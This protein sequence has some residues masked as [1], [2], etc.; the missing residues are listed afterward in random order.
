[1]SFDG[2]K[3]ST[4]D[5]DLKST[6]NDSGYGDDTV[7]NEFAL[8]AKKM[9][10]NK[11]ESMNEFALT[12]LRPAPPKMSVRPSQIR[13]H[14]FPKYKSM[15]PP[16]D[17]LNLL[18]KKSD[19]KRKIKFLFK[20]EHADFVNDQDTFDD[21]DEADDNELIEDS[22]LEMQFILEKCVLSLNIS[23]GL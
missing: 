18:G 12:F 11:F 5:D 20:S 7:Q 1:M 21:E 16:V 8:E 6:T 14:L 23:T 15:P 22:D 10:L 4:L 9:N 2:K 17:D 19:S 3:S 13:R